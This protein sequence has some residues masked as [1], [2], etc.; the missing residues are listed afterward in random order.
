LLSAFLFELWQRGH[1]PKFEHPHIWSTK[2]TVLRDLKLQC[3]S[4][5]EGALAT[6]SCTLNLRS[7]GIK[8]LPH[9]CGI[10]AGCILRRM[11]LLVGLG[12]TR[13]PEA[14]V[15]QDLGASNLGAAADSNYGID[16]TPNDQTIAT[17]G[18]MTH[19]E[20]ADAAGS[21]CSP[22]IDQVSFETARALNLQLPD[23]R[24][25]LLGLI[26]QHRADWHA[27]L[28]NLPEASWVRRLAGGH[29]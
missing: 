25:R 13:V 28:G 15:W 18:I 17:N 9:H 6:R 19:Q 8:G 4:V 26:E 11:A 1:R 12:T 14:Y 23:T 22:A 5:A 20:L 29:A 16:T 3:A 7:K 24:L 10:C 21:A 27:F 2:A